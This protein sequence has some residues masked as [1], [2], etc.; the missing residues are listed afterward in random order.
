[1]LHTYT[2]IKRKNT[3][4]HCFT[5]TKSLGILNGSDFIMANL[6]EKKKVLLQSLT[7]KGV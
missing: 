2:Y 5:G 4:S 3:H 1:M 6:P 7:L